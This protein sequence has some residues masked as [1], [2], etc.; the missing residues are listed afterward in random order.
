[1]RR[2]VKNPLT[3]DNSP[4]GGGRWGVR[5]SSDSMSSAELSVV[6]AEVDPLVVVGGM[7]DVP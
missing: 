3:R 1:M 6:R 2:E 7:V 5:G 4:V